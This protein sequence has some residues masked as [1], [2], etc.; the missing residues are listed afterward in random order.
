M[1]FTVAD[2][3]LATRILSFYSAIFIIIKINRIFEAIKQVKVYP[4]SY[5]FS[6]NTIVGTC[7]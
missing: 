3:D 2:G 6:A 5:I 1:S 7:N 4:E